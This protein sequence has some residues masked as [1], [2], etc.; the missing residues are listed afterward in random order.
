MQGYEV[1]QS[2]TAYPLVFLMIQSSD[3]LSNATGLTP[4]VT[5]SKNGGAFA[6]PSGAVSEI[7]NG[8]YKVA[9]NA[10]DTATLGPILLNATSAGADTTSMIFP[11]VAVNPQSSAYGLSLAKTTNITGFN[12]IAATAIVTSGAITT[13][14]GVAQASVAN[15]GGVGLVVPGS[16]TIQFSNVVGTSVY[17]GG[18]VASVT[19]P[20]T[21]TGTPAVNVTQIAGQTAN[22]AAAV[23]FPGSIGTSTYAGAD[24]NGTTTLLSR[25]TGSVALASQIPANFTSAT[26][27]SGGVFAATALANAPTGGGGSSVAVDGSG[28]VTLAPAGLDAI[29]VETGI[30]ARQALAPIL[31]SCAGL[32]SGAGVGPI[33]VNS[34]GSSNTQRLSATMDV[35]GNRTAVTLTLPT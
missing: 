21:I 23:T 5:I 28:R 33:Q 31:A 24:T 15:I 4:T 30:N 6:S 7:G 20:V 3:H 1:T 14:A 18:A 12:D 17:S 29:T 19:A 10:T 22:A 32:V 16:G 13:A 8:W 35:Y 27:V 26:F 11:V 25:I 34:A 9:G 2:S